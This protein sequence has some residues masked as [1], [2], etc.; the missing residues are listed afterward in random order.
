MAFE[1]RLE[2]LC[3]KATEDYREILQGADFLGL[4]TDDVEEVAEKITVAK[5]LHCYMITSMSES[6]TDVEALL[7]YDRPVTAAFEYFCENNIGM[8]YGIIEPINDFIQDTKHHIQ[9]VMDMWNA[10]PINE[11]ERIEVYMD[12]NRQIAAYEEQPERESDDY[13]LER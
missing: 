8:L 3:K 1:D 9:E 7:F 10:L 4:S 6:P 11:M 13:D 2:R 5:W 12:M